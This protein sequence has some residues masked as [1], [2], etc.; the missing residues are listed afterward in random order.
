M[1]VPTLH[2]SAPTLIETTRYLG[3]HQSYNNAANPD[4]YF[5]R[6]INFMDY[7]CTIIRKYVS[8]KPTDIFCC[9]LSIQKYQGRHTG[10]QVCEDQ[11]GVFIFWINDDFMVGLDPLCGILSPGSRLYGIPILSGFSDQVSHTKPSDRI[12]SRSECPDVSSVVNTRYN[13]WSVHNSRLNTFDMYR[14]LK[15][16]EEIWFITNGSI[17]YYIMVCYMS[18]INSEQMRWMNQ[19]FSRLSTTHGHITDCKLLVCMY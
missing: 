10:W 19:A 9:H 5:P 11:T 6:L 16:L 14:P 2:F 8:E 4:G 12:W 1:C 18:Q 3:P 7:N 15:C 13:C 17:Q